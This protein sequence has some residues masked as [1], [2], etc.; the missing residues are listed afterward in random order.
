MADPWLTPTAAPR[1]RVLT[2]LTHPLAVGLLAVAAAGYLAVF[3]PNRPGHYPTCPIL[4]LTGYYCPGCGG[5]RALHDLV[6]GHLVAA[7]SS[8]LLVV[9]AVPVAIGLWFEWTRNRLS[10]R[11]GRLRLPAWLGWSL[12]AVLLAFWGLRNLPQLHWLAP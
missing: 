5:L 8:N 3:D 11:A 9:L 6:H 10:G 7:L 12:L 2:A 4:W 1:S